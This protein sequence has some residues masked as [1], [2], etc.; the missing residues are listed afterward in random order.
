MPKWLPKWASQHK[1]IMSDLML[2]NGNFPFRNRKG[3]ELGLYIYMYMDFT[4]HWGLPCTPMQYKIPENW[5][6]HR[7]SYESY[8]QHSAPPPPPPV[9]PIDRFI[10]VG[11]CVGDTSA[12]GYT[13][14][15]QEWQDTTRGYNTQI[16]KE[17][18]SFIAVDMSL[19]CYPCRVACICMWR[20]FA[21]F[22]GRPGIVNS[23]TLQ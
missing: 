9:I 2:R 4:S 16:M 11:R 7:R 13:R 15:L 3:C 12:C 22:P 19:M 5:L 8:H 6:H 20:Y 21:Q 1:T 23:L 10:D 17:P 14:K 18:F